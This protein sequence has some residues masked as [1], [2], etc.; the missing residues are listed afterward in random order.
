MLTPSTPRLTAPNLSNWSVT[1]LTVLI[2]IAN[3]IPCVGTPC[4]VNDIFTE[5]TPTSFPPMSI[6]GPPEFPGLSGASVWMISSIMR[7]EADRILRPSAL[8]TPAVT[9]N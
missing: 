5:F 7:P 6:S 3:P 9:E 2:G 4:G 8:T 1:F